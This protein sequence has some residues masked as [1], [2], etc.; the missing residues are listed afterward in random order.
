MPEANP[1]SIHS[2]I[3]LCKHVFFVICKR[4]LEIHHE[5]IYCEI[6]LYLGTHFLHQE[7]DYEKLELFQLL[8]IGRITDQNWLLNKRLQFER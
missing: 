2:L 4:S 7:E 5:I 3:Y 8:R 1:P 6:H